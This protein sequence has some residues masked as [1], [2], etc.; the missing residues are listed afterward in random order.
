MGLHQTIKLL[1]KEGNYQQNE[2]ATYWKRED[3]CQQPHDK[4]WVYIK[5]MQRIHTS[6]IPKKQTA[7]LKDG[8]RTWIDI[9]SKHHLTSDDQQL[10]RCFY[11]AR[12]RLYLFLAAIFEHLMC[13]ST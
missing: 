7:Q 12:I 2:K 8:P 13:T 6:W 1:Y 10:S 9:F 5:N 11:F 4:E 3:T